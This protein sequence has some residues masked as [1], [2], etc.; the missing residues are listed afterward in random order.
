MKNTSLSLTEKKN[1]LQN[2]ITSS[3]MYNN[4]SSYLT[5][6]AILLKN[7]GETIMLEVTDAIITE[8]T[9]N[10]LNNVITNFI[11]KGIYGSEINNYNYTQMFNLHFQYVFNYLSVYRHLICCQISSSIKA[12]Y[13]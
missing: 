8:I 1:L 3:L 9:N 2:V 11:L 6:K 13:T 7:L 10:F 4:L 5:V 12:K